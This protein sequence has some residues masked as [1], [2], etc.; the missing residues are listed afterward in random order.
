M[1]PSGEVGEPNP[2]HEYT[3]VQQYRNTS[4]EEIVDQLGPFEYGEDAEM[5]GNLEYRPLQLLDTG[6]QYEGEFI[7]GSQ[8]REGKGKQIWADGSIY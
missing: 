1:D 6:A 7:R 3:D 8:V 2:P 5:R 4:V